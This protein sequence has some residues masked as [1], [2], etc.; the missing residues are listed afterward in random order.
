MSRNKDVYYDNERNK[1]EKANRIEELENM[2]ENHTRTERH[3]E[4][5]YDI[6]SLKKINEAREKQTEREEKIEIL[7]AKIINGEKTNSNDSEGLEKNYA[8]SKGYMENNE[9][10]M[11]EDALENMKEKQQNRR[12]EMTGLS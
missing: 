5:N 11:D 12:D 9:E 10:H 3:L 6:V 4:E 8:F 7:E 1:I 2:I